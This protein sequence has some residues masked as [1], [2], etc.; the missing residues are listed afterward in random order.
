MLLMW[1]GRI[2]SK[3]LSSKLISV[4]IS[5]QD[6]G[7]PQKDEDNGPNLFGRPTKKTIDINI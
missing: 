4:P 7:T 3:K 2:L 6:S 5:R 1:T